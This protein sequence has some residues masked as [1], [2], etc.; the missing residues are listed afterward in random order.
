MII[1]VRTHAGVWRVNDVGPDTTIRELR[2]RLSTEHNANLSDDSRQP[3]TLKPNPKGDQEPLS[4]ESTLQSLGLGHGDMVHL[5]L[6]ESIRDMAHE[7]AGGPKRINKDGTIEQQSFDEISNK[8]GFRPGMMSLR[9]MKMKWTLADFTEMNDQFTF[10]LKKPEKGV[11]TKVTLDSAAC[12]SFQSFVRQFGFHRAR[13]GYL[14]GQF[15]DDD[16]KVRVECVY[17]PPQENYPEGF[18]VSEDPKGD[19]VEALAGLLGLKR[20]GWIFAHPPREEGF[21]FS[22]AE[23]ITAATLQLEAADGINDTPFVTVKVTAEEDGS[24]HFDAFQVSKQCMEMVAEGALEVGENPGHC[25][26]PKTFTAIVEMKEAKEPPDPI[27]PSIA[28]PTHLPQPPAEKKV[29]ATMFLNTVPIEQHE[30]AKFLHDFPRANRDGVMQTWDDVK[31]QLGRAGGQGFTYVD[32]ISDFHLLLF[33][34]AFLDMQTDMPKIC[35][36]VVDREKPLD[37][38]FKFLINNFAGLD[39]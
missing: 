19:T 38:G 28:L 7:E 21:L 36:S 9:S 12:N 14:Y 18:Q 34:T 4:L 39:A 16:T 22:S 30:S 2:Q 31:R 3:L 24:A 6:D 11:C 8:T 13:M 17:E 29:D 1:R 10:R 32:V 35:D 15:T 37:D 23:V 27:L 25:V 33:L 26:V 5:S 20:V